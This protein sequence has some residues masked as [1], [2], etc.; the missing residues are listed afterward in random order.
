MN[1]KIII[2]KNIQQRQVFYPKILSA[3]RATDIPAFYSEWF[4]MNFEKGYFEKKNPFNQKTYFVSVDDVRFIVF[5][6]KNPQAIIEKLDFLDDKNINYY[7]QFTLNDYPEYEL[8]LPALEKRIA[9]FKELS[10][11]ISKQK[12]VWRF[13]PLILSDKINE[14]DLLDRIFKLGQKIHVYTEKLVFS[15]VDLKYRKVKNSLHK[16]GAYFYDFD[17]SMKNR[18]AEQLA[19]YAKE[20]GIEIATC[21]ENNDFSGFGISCNK[22]IDDELIVRIAEDDEKLLDYLGCSFDIFEN[23]IICKNAKK[24]KGQRKFCHCI[25]SKDIG[26]YNSCLHQC[27]YCY[28]NG[29]FGKSKQYYSKIIKLL[30]SEI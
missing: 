30:K 17:A 9:V 4:F 1:R 16:Y 19:K 25:E 14:T 11:K 27:I 2:D 29:D 15:F 28:A 18:I 20:W 24:D 10:N 5:W 13:D 6:S 22:C 21:A 3:S 26:F 12:V 7:F 8:N 23:K